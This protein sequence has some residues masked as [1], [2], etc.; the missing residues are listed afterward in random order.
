[1]WNGWAGLKSCTRYECSGNAA[2]ASCDVVPATC[3]KNSDCN[4][5]DFK[6]YGTCVDGCCEYGNVPPPPKNQEI[7]NNFVDDDG[8]NAIDCQDSDCALSPECGGTP[9]W[10]NSLFAALVATL[11]AMLAFSGVYSYRKK[12]KNKAIIAVL[13]GAI[14]WIAVFI[15]VQAMD[16][17][18]VDPFALVTPNV[19]ECVSNWGWLSFLDVPNYLCQAGQIAEIISYLGALI[20]AGLAAF[21]LY[22]TLSRIREFANKPLVIGSFAIISFII[23]F[24]L[25]RALFWVGV[26]A[27]ILFAI[28]K[29]VMSPLEMVGRVA[30]RFKN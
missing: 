17:P 11:V 25:A 27:L 20:I 4:V 21:L 7:C 19:Q 8:D 22:R 6:G 2:T 29:Y 12:P 3:S 18:I 16:L 1:M 15:L 9:F 30:G 13:A 23:V 14:V 26:V 24:I 5:G 28:F 10:D